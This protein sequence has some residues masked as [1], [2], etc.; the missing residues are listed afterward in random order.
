MGRAHRSNFRNTV[1]NAWLFGGV[2][3]TY[4]KKWAPAEP[5][6]VYKAA[7]RLLKKREK[8]NREIIA[9]KLQ[10]AR[11]QAKIDASKGAA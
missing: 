1:A 6:A 4:T 2:S 9:L 5:S 3:Q 10:I 11:I 7:T 8:E